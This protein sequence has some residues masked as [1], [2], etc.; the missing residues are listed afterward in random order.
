MVHAMVSVN[1]AM[2]P[3]LLSTV[4]NY[5]HPHR[6]PHVWNELI[7]LSNTYSGKWLLLG[8]FNCSL[9][10]CEK[11]SGVTPSLPKILKSREC[12]TQC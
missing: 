11:K 12:M 6:Q 10:E 1:K 9:N 5:A 4:Y 7:N 3:F 2:Q 8:D